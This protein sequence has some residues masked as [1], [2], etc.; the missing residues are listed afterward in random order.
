M[1]KRRLSRVGRPTLLAL[2]S[3]TGFS[4]ADD[5]Q[6]QP[7][8]PIQFPAGND[9]VSVDFVVRDKKGRPLRG[10]TSA[11]VEVFEDG[12][13]QKIESLQW[14]ERALEK[15]PGTGPKA[16]AVEPAATHDPLGGA[17]AD[18]APF[19]ALLFDHLSAKAR[20]SATDA[21]ND[22]TARSAA[23]AETGVFLAD[24]GL[25]TLQS[26]TDDTAAVRRA[27]EQAVTIVPA[28]HGVNEIRDRLR[29]LRSQ[30]NGGA[31]SMSAGSVAAEFKG[32]VFP[33]MGS[34]SDIDAFA[35]NMEIKMLEGELEMGDLQAA[36]GPIGA[37]LALV[38]ALELVPG[39]K[40]VV[41]FSEGLSVPASVEPMFLSLIAAANR[42]NVSVYTVDAAGLRVLSGN[43]TMRREQLALTQ[44]LESQASRTDG[45]GGMSLSLLEQNEA[46]L[47]LSPERSLWR[48][49]DQT[50][51]LLAQGSNDLGNT[52]RLLDEDLRAYYVLSYAPTNENYDGRFRT[53][54]LK[55]K[56]P[57][58]TLQSR[59]GYLAVKSRLPTPILVH[60][61][62]AL[63]A[64]EGARSATSVPCRLRAFDMPM[65]D[66]TSR[67]S[68]L[69]EVPGTALANDVDPAT[70]HYRQDFTIVVLVRDSSG[71]VLRK[72][73]QHYEVEGPA[74]RLEAAHRTSTL[75]FREADLPPGSYKFDGAVWDA[76]A[77]ASGVAR[78]DLTLAGGETSLGSLML[79][80]D[81]EGAK[82][83]QVSATHPLRFGDVILY[84]NMGEAQ[85]SKLRPELVFAVTARSRGPLPAEMV[86]SCEGRERLKQPLT[87]PA[88][89]A[90]GIAR[91]VGSLPLAPL[92]DGSCELR[93]SAEGSA[94]RQ[95]RSARFAVSP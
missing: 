16:P 88:P 40:A 71:R 14:I 91:F 66:G 62:P 53:I 78:E 36:R 38:N 51:G 59:K 42:A 56:P 79:V 15:K 39:R 11:D 86:V 28:A 9:R 5:V 93:L 12:V 82:G 61:A 17:V 89:A 45:G 29:V 57:H 26:F 70:G 84:P 24:Q 49:A 23:R 73:S 58:G 4:S 32:P 3:V 13:P 94:G 72:M 41:L 60:E 27:V 43:E 33:G 68:V 75:F 7:V 25:R 10:L 2:L 31:G 74:D 47:R 63:A 85:H 1:A 6:Q 19:V 92:G 21:A 30:S 69:V 55:V 90:D 34:R 83:T 77:N 80:R 65:G 44:Q 50:G 54:S 22:W 76:K 95:T 64:L 81:A 20:K 48:L 35:D 52:L 46:S 8:P 67:A 87:L 18:G 37:M